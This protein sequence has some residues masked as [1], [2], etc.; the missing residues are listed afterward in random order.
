MILQIWLDD[1]FLVESWIVKDP[2]NDKSSF[3]GYEPKKGDWYGMYKIK[4]TTQFWDEYI[5]T[6]KVKG[7]SV[8]GYFNDKIISHGRNA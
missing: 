8:E 2:K 7:F 1:V 4:D 6:G 3:Y 5:K